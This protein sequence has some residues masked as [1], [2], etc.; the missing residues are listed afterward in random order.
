MYVNAEFDIFAPKPVQEA[1]L[2]TV[3]TTYNPIATIDQ[4]H[5]EFSIP[6]HS[7]YYI[8]H[9]IHMCQVN[10]WLPTAKR[11]TRMTIRP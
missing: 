3:E 10:Y 8:D 4:S 2:E 1:V 7:D 11:W 6:A 9:N 5:L